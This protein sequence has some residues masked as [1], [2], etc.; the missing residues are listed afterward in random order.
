MSCKTGTPDQDG[1][2]SERIAKQ[3]RK[4]RAASYKGKKEGPRREKE[5]KWPTDQGGMR[6]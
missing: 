5:C 1:D 6:K 2:R 4:A 3:K